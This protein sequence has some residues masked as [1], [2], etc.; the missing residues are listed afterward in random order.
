[1]R[2]DSSQIDGA[3][4]LAPATSGARVLPATAVGAGGAEATV[5]LRGLPSLRPPL[6]WRVPRALRE[7]RAG[8][9]ALASIVICVLAM[10][11]YESG[12][13]TLLTPRSSQIFVSWE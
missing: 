3:A 10:V 2:Q 12:S 11:V 13:P 5:K 6:A 7:P 8:R 1:M 4:A 9:I